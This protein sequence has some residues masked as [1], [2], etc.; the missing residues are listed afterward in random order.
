MDVADGFFS[1]AEP[2]D[3]I[4]ICGSVMYRMPYAPIGRIVADATMTA[5]LGVTVASPPVDTV[6]S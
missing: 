3:G 1:K 5:G 6:G 4:R 2:I